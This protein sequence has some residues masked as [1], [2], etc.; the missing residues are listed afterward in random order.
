MLARTRI[1]LPSSKSLEL[2]YERRACICWHFVEASPPWGLVGLSSSKNMYMLM[3]TIFYPME[4]VRGDMHIWLFTGHYRDQV[5]VH[6]QLQHEQYVN[7]LWAKLSRRAGYCACK[8]KEETNAVY[9]LR[10]GENHVLLSPTPSRPGQMRGCC[11]VRPRLWVPSHQES[12]TTSTV[13]T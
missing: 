5:L 12:G 7:Q 2:C 10:M 9:Y 11:A 1:I 6:V 4:T 8:C 13:I 3:Y